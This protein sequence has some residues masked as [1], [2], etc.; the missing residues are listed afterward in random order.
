MAGQASHPRSLLSS[1]LPWQ[2]AQEGAFTSRQGEDGTRGPSSRRNESAGGCARRVLAGQDG[3]AAVRDS[4]C[5]QQHSRPPNSREA[6]PPGRPGVRGCNCPL[7]SRVPSSGT[8][9]STALHRL[10]CAQPCRPGA[11]SAGAESL[12]CGACRTPRAP[13]QGFRPGLLEALGLVGFRLMPSWLRLSCVVWGWGPA[14]SWL[15]AGG[16]H[17]LHAWHSSVVSRASHSRK[18][19]SE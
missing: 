14:P 2:E 4:G 8:S 9:V 7:A 17:H 11:R 5:L 12:A 10:S 15:L 13:I 3:G 19:C 1:L 18:P 6:W 16:C